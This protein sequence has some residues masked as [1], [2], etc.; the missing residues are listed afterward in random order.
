VLL[1][2]T[3]TE[4]RTGVDKKGKGDKTEEIDE[5][6]SKGQVRYTQCF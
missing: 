6:L 3:Q 4:M 2:E 5:G 1:Y